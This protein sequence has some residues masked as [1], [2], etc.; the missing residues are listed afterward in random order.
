MNRFV[1]G[2]PSMRWCQCSAFVL[3]VPLACLFF[4]ASPLVA[5]ALPNPGIARGEDRIVVIPSSEATGGKFLIEKTGHGGEL[6]RTVESCEVVIRADEYLRFCVLSEFKTTEQAAKVRSVG[7]I[8]EIYVGSSTS[9]SIEVLAALLKAIEVR[10]LE[11]GMTKEFSDAHLGV[12]K[13]AKRITT[14]C[15]FGLE[16]ISGQGIEALAAVSGLEKVRISGCRRLGDEACKIL[17][18]FKELRDLDFHSQTVTAKCLEYLGACSALE[19]LAISGPKDLANGVGF[20]SSCAKLKA[21]EVSC[22][23]LD[24][25]GVSAL[26]QLVGLTKI[27]LTYVHTLSAEA[28]KS[29]S[30]LKNLQ[31]LVLEQCSVLDTKCLTTIAALSGLV[32]I[33]FRDCRDL[34]DKGLACLASCKSLGQLAIYNCKSVSKSAVNEL[35]KSCPELDVVFWSDR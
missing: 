26:G 30:T 10:Q 24:E 23:N 33:T 4:I 14:L 34:D 19:S 11:F 29:W 5:Q 16:E 18:Q 2:F 28:M 12:L 8:E 7:Q 35:P 32:S 31:V 20:L 22:K 21:L 17:S 3:G 25:T 13:Q 1:V 9:P 27:S 6:S 15:L